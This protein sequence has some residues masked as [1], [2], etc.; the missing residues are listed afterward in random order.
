MGDSNFGSISGLPDFR[1]L[2][3]GSKQLQYCSEVFRDVAT[4]IIEMHDVGFNSSFR[5]AGVIQ[6]F[7]Q[8][9]VTKR[10]RLPFQGRFEKPEFSLA[11]SLFGGVV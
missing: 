5:L 7:L 4:P 1:K 9:R 11:W 10:P 8:H 6:L 2:Q 3:Y